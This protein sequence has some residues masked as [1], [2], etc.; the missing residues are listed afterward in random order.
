M[1]DFDLETSRN[2]GEVGLNLPEVSDS[3]TAQT[4]HWQDFPARSVVGLLVLRALVR[5]LVEEPTAQAVA[6]ERD[7]FVLGSR[8]RAWFEICRTISARERHFTGAWLAL[9]HQE[10]S[11][12]QSAFALGGHSA[13]RLHRSLT[14]RASATQGATTRLAVGAAAR[15]PT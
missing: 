1:S 7:P 15:P 4:Q 10:S 13:P 6:F 3:Q 12:C 14:F 2:L 8:A 11:G 5:A 9:L